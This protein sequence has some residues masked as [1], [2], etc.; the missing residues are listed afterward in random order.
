MSRKFYVAGVKFHDLHKVISDIE[1]GTELVIEPDFG[2]PY[3]PNA[4]KITFAGAM[5]G[6][7]PRK[8]SAETSS[9]FELG[10]H[11]HCAAT[12]VNPTAKPWEQ[13]EV[14]VSSNIDEEEINGEFQ[15]N[16]YVDEGGSVS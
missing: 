14:E 9:L 15:H 8:F 7:V 13:L 11:V 2:N 12:K 6:Y 10:A 3:D 4:I 1:E 5:I 16:D